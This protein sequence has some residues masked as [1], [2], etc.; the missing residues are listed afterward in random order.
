[1]KKLALLSLAV[2]VFAAFPAGAAAPFDGKLVALDAGHGGGEVGA[3]GYC[4]GTPVAEVD[5]NLAVRSL[6]AAKLAAAGADVFLVPQISSRRDRVAEAEAAGADVLISIHHNG[7]SNTATDYTQS[8]VTQ[9]NDKEL[10]TP[11]H[12]A[13]LTALGLPN[14]GIKSDGYGMTVYGSLPGVLTEAFF[15][16][17]EEEACDF[18]NT[19]ARVE[20]EAQAM[21][22]GLA[23]YFSSFG[24]SDGGPDK[25]S[26]WPSCRNQ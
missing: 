10:A 12:A 20:L 14:K 19:G 7:S 25:C 5:V 15:V 9:K 21:F 11:V 13:L 17:N 4:S 1:M 26:P 8:F 24:G 22:D 16:T 3:T 18:L 2:L 6:L 23:E